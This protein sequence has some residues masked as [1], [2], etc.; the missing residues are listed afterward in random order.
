MTNVAAFLGVALANVGVDGGLA[1]VGA[2]RIVTPGQVLDLEA[3]VHRVRFPA[4]EHNGLAT[5][6]GA[7]HLRE[8]PGFAGFHNLEACVFQA[9]LVFIDEGLD[10][11]VA[12]VTRFDT[13][14][15]AA[16]LVLEFGNIGEVFQAF[17]VQLFGDRQG[18][19]GVFQVSAHG[20]HGAGITVL[21]D[22][23]FHGRHPVA[24]EDVHVLTVGQGL[25]GHRHRNHRGAWLVAEALEDFAGGRGSDGDV[26]PA[27]IREVDGLTLC[28]FCSVRQD[29]QTQHG[30]QQQRG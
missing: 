19:F 30:G 6:G 7:F 13:V 9:E 4:E 26:G 18:V 11:A 12:V 24:E 23:V 20:F 28:R 21:L 25:V 8:H 15:L 2:E 5:F 22:V 14:D 17:V 16:Q 1:V 27:D 10:G 29:W 3:G